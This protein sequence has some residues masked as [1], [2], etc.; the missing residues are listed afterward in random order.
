LYNADAHTWA[1]RDRAIAAG[2]R[3]AIRWEAMTPDERWVTT[4]PERMLELSIDLERWPMIVDDLSRL[5][6]SPPIVAEGSTVLPDLLRRGSRTPPEP[7]GSCRPLS[8]RAGADGLAAGRLPNRCRLP[9]GERSGFQTVSIR[10]RSA[11]GR[12][13]ARKRKPAVSSG[14]LVGA[15]RDRTGD[16]RLASR[17]P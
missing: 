8:K 3:G 14:F 13:I 2:H 15:Y 5:P 7:S 16:L 17:L 12:A 9:T 1:H 6:A 10:P 4:T 11:V